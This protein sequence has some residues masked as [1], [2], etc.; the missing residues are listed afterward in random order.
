V[1]NGAVSVQYVD[2]DGDKIQTSFEGV[3]MSAANFDAQVTAENAIVTAIDAISLLTRINT[4]RTAVTDPLIVAN[5]VNPFAQTN[6]QWIVEYVD[7]T[8]G[9]VYT[10]RIGGA[11]LSLADTLYNGAP[12]LT[13]GPG[14]AGEDLKT[15]LDAYARHDAHTI[16]VQA[17][18]FRE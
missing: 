12:A 2:Y 18:Y 4:V 14:G 15:A 13:G 9:G 8:T 10:W 5:P 7:D 3:A 6:I 16:T 11:D 1:A 17:I